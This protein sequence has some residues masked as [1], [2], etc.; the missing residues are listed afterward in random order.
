MCLY[1]HKQL[2]NEVV[3]FQNLKYLFFSVCSVT[4]EKLNREFTE[5]N[6][7][8]TQIRKIEPENN[9]FDL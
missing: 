8:D 4:E 6:H 3:S 2:N 7:S 1:H 9:N 5:E